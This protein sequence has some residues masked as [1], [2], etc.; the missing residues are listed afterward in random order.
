MTPTRKRLLALLAMYL[1][2]IVAGHYGGEY[3]RAYWESGNPN[4]RASHARYFLLLGV[5]L[6]I[7]FLAVPFVPGMEISLAL[8]AAFGKD[9]ALVVYLASIV[10]L[11]ISY[12][13]GRFFSVRA[14]TALFKFLQ[15]QDAA[16]F[17][18][19]LEHLTPQQRLAILTTNAPTRLTPFLIRYRYVALALA[20]NI[21]GNAIIG[22]GGGIAMVAGIRGLFRMLPFAIT[23]AIALAPVP[24]AFYVMGR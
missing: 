19:R 16:E 7:A 21:P 6:Y 22:G 11:A 17:A 3:L 20:L 2:I 1:V 9:A 15:L 13:V 23:I 10:S 18:Q 8:F 24:F 4:G 14:I 5:G 12:S